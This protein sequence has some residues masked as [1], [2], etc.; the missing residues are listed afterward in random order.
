MH[1]PN[2]LA[3]LAVVCTFSSTVL[4]GS[5]H[6]ARTAEDGMTNAL[7]HRDAILAQPQ[8][9]HNRYAPP[10]SRASP[11]FQ[12]RN[13]FPYAEAIPDPQLGAILGGIGR[14]A[15]RLPGKAGKKMAKEQGKNANGKGGSGKN[16][17][18]WHTD[19]KIPG[20]KWYTNPHP[21]TMP[22]DL[23]ESLSMTGGTRTGIDKMIY[24][25]SK[26]EQLKEWKNS[27]SVY[28]VIPST[29]N[30]KSVWSKGSYPGRP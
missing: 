28:N 23:K 6:K 13:P 14:A 30:D 11:S 2:H 20:F 10:D 1:I 25:P 26:E 21:G 8:Y 19:P 7:Y 24:P 12:R 15:T 29:K 4:A 9:L 18:V 5:F 22:D 3:V 27:R 16:N 17:L